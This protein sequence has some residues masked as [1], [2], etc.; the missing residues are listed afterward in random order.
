[1]EGMPFYYRMIRGAVGKKFVIK[2]YKGGRIVMT[3]FPNMSG[4]VATEK[5]SV[6]RDL[7]REAV[8]WAKWIIADEERK[9]IFKST[10]PRKKRRKVYQAALQMYI[11]QK[12]NKRWLRKML[13]NI[14]Q[15]GAVRFV[16]VRRKLA[17]E[18]IL[19][20]G[21][22][23]LLNGN[24][25]WIKEHC[26]EDLELPQFRQFPHFLIFSFSHFPQRGKSEELA[27]GG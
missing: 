27:S 4:V 24:S 14:E 6:R 13:E 3:K 5:Q 20:S 12:G 17:V 11:R 10:L 7:F 1:M 16:D 25:R 9:L 18:A 26:Y 2:H 15:Q 19:E 23:E 22:C 8:V 21:K